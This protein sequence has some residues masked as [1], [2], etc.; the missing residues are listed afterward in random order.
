[1]KILIFFNTRSFGIVRQDQQRE[2]WADQQ[3]Q[4]VVENTDLLGLD[5]EDPGQGAAVGA[6]A[7]AEPI[8]EGP[9]DYNIFHGEG[10]PPRVINPEPDTSGAASSAPMQR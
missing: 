3:D 7:E 6:P 8:V 10:S 5:E 4:P 1:M 2:A 9:V